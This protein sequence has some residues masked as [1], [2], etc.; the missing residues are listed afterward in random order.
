ML[1]GSKLFRRQFFALFILIA[2]SSTLISLT[3]GL[4]TSSELLVRQRTIAERYRDQVKARLIEWLESRKTAVEAASFVLAESGSAQLRGQETTARINRL[5]KAHPDFIDLLVIDAAG[6]TANARQAQ[7]GFR[8]I[9]LADREYFREA[10]ESGVGV[11]GFFEGRHTGRRIMTIAMRF[12]SADGS[13]FVVAAPITVERVAA[14]LDSIGKGGFGSAYLVDAAAR[15]L[16]GNEGDATENEAA[17]GAALGRTG[18]AIY[19]G[20]DGGTV[21]GAY[22]RLEDFDAGL[23]VE[24]RN[25]LLM[26]PIAGL[27]RFVLLI[28]VAGAILAALMAFILSSQVFSPIQELIRAVDGIA[29]SDYSRSLE[30]SAGNELDALIERV[31]RMQRRIAERETDLRDDASRDSL[32]GLYNH[33]A[34]ME[35][36]GRLSRENSDAALCFA[37]IDIDHFKKINDEYGHQAG[38]AVLIRLAELLRSA[39]RGDDLVGRY[40]GE[41]FA[42]VLKEWTETDNEAFCERLRERIER[43]EFIYE[44]KRIPVTASIGWACAAPGAGFLSAE[45]IGN[46]DAALYRAKAGGRNRVEQG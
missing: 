10:M 23:G 42:V 14:A 1:F 25:D 21:V 7:P 2:A 15:R 4:R 28:G 22:A 19:R 45:L 9:D 37:M 26:D 39:V 13:F 11:M 38:D 3:I 8:E 18:T 6:K 29:E 34:I 43:E 40:G 20:K 35:Y 30:L 31:N 24:L 44:D 12:A 46:A 27:Q 17:R 5:L 33:G 32:T 41:E 36:M 16:A